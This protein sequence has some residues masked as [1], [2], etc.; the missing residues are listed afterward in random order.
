[1]IDLSNWIKYLIFSLLFVVVSIFII[2]VSVRHQ[3]NIISTQ[4]VE[5]ALPSVSIGDV[6]TDDSVNL[7]LDSLVSNVL[8]S[9]ANSHKEQGKDIQVD[10]VFLDGDGNVTNDDVDIQSIQFEVKLLGKNERVESTSRENI[11]IDY[12]EDKFGR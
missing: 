6:R 8:L 2:F 9:I 5:G 11:E 7:D 10:Y 3:T 4:E 1:M 12:L